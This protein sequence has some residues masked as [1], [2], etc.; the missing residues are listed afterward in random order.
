MHALALAREPDR[1]EKEVC[2]SVSSRY[3]TEPKEHARLPVLR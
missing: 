1:R 2:V 3:V